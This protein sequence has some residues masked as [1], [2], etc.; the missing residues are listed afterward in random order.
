MKKLKVPQSSFSME[1]KKRKKI[2][3]KRKKRIKDRESNLAP[4]SN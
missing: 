1:R 3:K 2:R 4:L